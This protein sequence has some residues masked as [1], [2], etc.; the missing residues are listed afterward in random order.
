V[1]STKALVAQTSP[2]QG[3]DDNEWL[4]ASFGPSSIS[5]GVQY[6]LAVWGDEN[7]K[8]FWV[9]NVSPND[10][11][12]RYNYINKDYSESSGMPDPLDTSGKSATPTQNRKLYYGVYYTKAGGAAEETRKLHTMGDGKITFMGTDGRIQ[13][14]RNE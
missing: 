9:E 3:V 1:S 2:F 11:I 13:F 4:T 5:A 10:G 12:A 6:L 7:A 14:I 8:Y